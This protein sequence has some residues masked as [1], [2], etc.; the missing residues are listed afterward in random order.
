MY[1]CV[2]SSFYYSNLCIMPH[3]AI[4]LN[5]EWSVYMSVALAASSRG[6]HECWLYQIYRVFECSWRINLSPSLFLLALSAIDSLS[7][8]QWRFRLKD[9][10]ELTASDRVK[11]LSPDSRT[12]ILILS[13]V[14]ESDLGVYECRA[15]NKVSTQSSKARLIITGSCRF[16]RVHGRTIV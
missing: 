12:F 1:I 16:K 10:I 3:L 4:R 7:W 2:H 14:E 5:N 15:T 13:R 9:S 8:C 6:L 11:F